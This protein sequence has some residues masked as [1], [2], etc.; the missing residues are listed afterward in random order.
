MATL[1]VLHTVHERSWEHSR[2]VYPVISR[3]S[4]GLSIGINLNPDKACNFDC[5]YCCVD[6]TNPAAPAEL[7][8]SSL[9]AELDHL[10]QLALSNELY[11]HAPFDLTPAPLRRLADIAFSGDGEPT[12]CLKFPDAAKVVVECLRRAGVRHTPIVLI[13][14]ATLLTRPSVVD[15][16]AY[17][18]R[19]QLRIW[20]KLDAGTDAYYRT[21]DR[22]SVPFARVLENIRQT[23]RI[24]PLWIQSLFMRLHSRPPPPAEIDAYLARLVELRTG[25]CQI[26]GVQVCTVARRTAEP[27]VTPLPDADL[28]HIAAR[29]R[30]LGVSAEPFYGPT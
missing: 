12:A 9:R 28:D 22:S 15:T 11:T 24:R 14:N 6:R 16:L 7:D 21:V 13:T 5:V 30:S 8:L 19:H 2:F 17:L 20:A 26:A 29:V 18:D 23:G 3:R 10:L 27:Y 4:R 25:G 1:T